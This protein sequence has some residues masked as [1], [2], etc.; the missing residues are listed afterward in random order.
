MNSIE[1]D[2]VSMSYERDYSEDDGSGGGGGVDGGDFVEKGGVSS[3]TQDALLAL[4]S[5]RSK[6]QVSIPLFQ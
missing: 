6:N 2:N 5:L 1:E 3:Q 4:S